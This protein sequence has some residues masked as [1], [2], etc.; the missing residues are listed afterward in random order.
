MFRG[1]GVPELLII[2]AIL[3]LLF[4]ATRLPQVGGALGKAIRE[5]RKS[6]RGEDEEESEPKKTA[7]NDA[8]NS[9]VRK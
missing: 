8:A 7:G 3:L 4:G 9:Q 1:F 5:F 6:H 2:F